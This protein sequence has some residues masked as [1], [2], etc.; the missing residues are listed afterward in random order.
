M[1]KSISRHALIRSIVLPLYL[2]FYSFL[3]ISFRDPSSFYL[4]YAILSFTWRQ[5]SAASCY[6]RAFFSRTFHLYD[7]IASV[8]SIDIAGS[9]R[10]SIL[11][12]TARW[13]PFA[14]WWIYWKCAMRISSSDGRLRH[15]KRALGNYA[16]RLYARL[17]A[18]FSVKFPTAI[19]LPSIIHRGVIERLAA[20]RSQL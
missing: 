14:R 19:F 5:P 8:S 18:P 16:C 6:T 20:I 12:F 17:R 11:D 10:K 2:C 7:G 13:L 15:W 9:V 3:N 4:A 1:Y